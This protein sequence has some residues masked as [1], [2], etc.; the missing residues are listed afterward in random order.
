[1]NVGE[2][3]YSCFKNSHGDIRYRRYTIVEKPRQF[4]TGIPFNVITWL[5]ENNVP[6]G[7]HWS[8]GA[9]SNGWVSTN[10]VLVEEISKETYEVH[11][12]KVNQTMLA[13]FKKEDQILS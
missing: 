6:Y 2:I 7:K 11:V 12:N 4:E 8:P 3:L 13:F 9:S 10:Y 5:K 1:M